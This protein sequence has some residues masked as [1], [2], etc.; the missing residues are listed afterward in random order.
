MDYY[1][2]A[3]QSQDIQQ[4]HASSANNFRL[5]QIAHKSEAS[6]HHTNWR[7]L[8]RIAA[9]SV[10]IVLMATAGIS[11]Q[12]QELDP[13]IEPEWSHYTFGLGFNAMHQGDYELAIEYLTKSIDEDPE[14]ASA[15]A[16]R[17]TAFYL[18]GD[19]AAALTDYDEAI[20]L[21]P[22]FSSAYHWRGK[23]YLAM[24]NIEQALADT[25]TA[26]QIEPTYAGAY[27]TLSA[28]Y[29]E[30]GNYLMVAG[31]VAQYIMHIEAVAA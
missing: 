2:R 8:G 3:Q 5:A 15:Y 25:Q 26:I 19:Y 14:Y 12:A 22:E 28:I 24:G 6:N 13:V 4:Q 18:S 30:K 29:M 20:G 9:I 11:T 16:Y 7:K 10:F 27:E 1:Q 17:A 31:G 23:T 21:S